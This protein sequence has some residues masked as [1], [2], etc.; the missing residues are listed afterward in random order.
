MRRA[1]IVF[2]Y[3]CMASEKSLGLIQEYRKARAVHERCLCYTF[4][5]SKD[6][7]HI[8]SRFMEGESEGLTEIKIPATKVKDSAEIYA[9]VEAHLRQC[10]DFARQNGIVIARHRL[11]VL[12][13]EANLFDDGLKQVI[14]DIAH[15]GVRVVCAGLDL[16]FRGE[17]FPLRGER[18]ITVPD[19]MGI[20]TELHRHYARCSYLMEDGAPCGENAT[21]SQRYRDTEHNEPSHYDDPTLEVDPKKYKPVCETHHT[22]PGKNRPIIK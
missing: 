8:A 15:N 21:R 18:H 10:Y 13:D 2:H 14:E 22:V 20:A 16:D 12:I 11:N 5:E 17:P 4:H 9:G 7:G 19:I 3:G 6:G 1:P